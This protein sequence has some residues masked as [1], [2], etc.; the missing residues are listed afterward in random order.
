MP[1]FDFKCQE[2]GAVEEI[3]LKINEDIEEIGCNICKSSMMHKQ[4]SACSFTIKGYCYQNSE[5]GK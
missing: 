2:C 1:L 5:R 4:V 3:L